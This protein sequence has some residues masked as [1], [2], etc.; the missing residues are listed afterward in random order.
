MLYLQC[1]PV[2]SRVW[3]T[4]CSR[5]WLTG[6]AVRIALGTCRGYGVRRLVPSDSYEA[7]CIVWAFVFKQ[8]GAI[9]LES[10]TSFCRG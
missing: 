6:S 2:R 1:L 8:T 7:F 10:R 4:R 9:C 3:Y 5:P